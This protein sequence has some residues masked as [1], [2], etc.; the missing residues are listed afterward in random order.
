MLY[1]VVSGKGQAALLAWLQDTMKR[2][3]DANTVAKNL[4]S[5]IA[6]SG[7]DTWQS[8]VENPLDVWGY[9]GPMNTRYA[10]P[11]ELSRSGETQWFEFEVDEI[12]IADIPDYTLFA[13]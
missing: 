1:C 9:Y 7:P 2:P 10:L 11:P 3:E 5:Q 8:I 13:Q 4:L 12:R 6:R